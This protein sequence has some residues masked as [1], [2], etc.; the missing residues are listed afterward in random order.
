M[1]KKLFF[2]GLLAFI[3]NNLMAQTEAQLPKL[4]PVTPTAANLIKVGMGDV[5]KAT[6]A[7]TANM[8]LYEV[9]VG[10]F[11]LP[12]SL[13][14]F[15]QGNKTEEQSTRVGFGWSL[16]AGGVISRK[17]MDVAD[18]LGARAAAPADLAAETTQN[19]DYFTFGQNTGT[20]TSGA[21]T[22]PDEY[23]FS[24]GGNSGKFII[25][26]AGNPVVISHQN[27][28]IVTFANGGSAGIIT[29]TT[30]DGITYYFGG[31]AYDRIIKT[32]SPNLKTAFYLYKI[33]LPTG[34]Y[35]NLNYEKIQTESASGF[36]ETLALAGNCEQ[37]AGQYIVSHSYS[38]QFTQN[39]VCYL[40]N[41]TTSE[42]TKVDFI[43]EAMP[44]LSNDKRLTGL[45][46]TS[47]NLKEVKRY[48]FSYT[49]T[50]GFVNQYPNSPNTYTGGR[51]GRFYL[52]GI[53]EQSEAAGQV[54]N[55]PVEY[56]GNIATEYLQD[57]YG[58]DAY[59]FKNGK[60]NSS[61]LPSPDAYSTNLTGITW[62]D[63]S[64]DWHA[65]VNGMLK[66][67]A[68]PTKGTETFYYEPN[69]ISAYV[70]EPDMRAIQK[71]I[72]GGDQPTITYEYLT[73]LKDQTITLNYTHVV[74]S[75]HC[76]AVCGGCKFIQCIVRDETTNSQLASIYF[77]GEGSTY[78][79][80]FQ[81]VAGHQ[82][83]F[84][85]S[86]FPA[87]SCNRG[88]IMI[89]YDAAPPGPHLVNKEVSGVR[90][91]RIEKADQF[92][93]S[94]NKYFIYA[95]LAELNKSS[96]ISDPHVG[97]FSVRRSWVCGQGGACDACESYNYSSNGI[98][99]VQRMENSHIYY[100]NIIETTDPQMTNG[101]TEY[102]F[103]NPIVSAA[104]VV[105]RGSDMPHPADIT[106]P[107]YEGLV[108]KELV[109]DKN[110]QTKSVTE[111][112]YEIVTPI[113]VPVRTIY[114]TRLYTPYY[115]VVY[116][117][118]PAVILRN[119]LNSFNVSEN[120]Y[121]PGWVRIHDT[122]NT[123]Y[124]NAG[125]PVESATNYIY[126]TVDNV[127]PSGVT[128]TDSKGN[129]I[130]SEKKYPTDFPADPVLAA[131]VTANMISP[132]VEESKMQNLTELAKTKVI[133]QSNGAPGG[134][135]QPAKIQ[136]KQTETAAMEDRIL[137][138]G[139]DNKGNLTEVSKASDSKI[140]YLWDY[141]Q[142]LVTAEVKNSVKEDIAY[143]SFEADSKGNFT[144]AGNT[145]TDATA[146]T[147]KKVYDLSGG[148]ITAPA[149]AGTGK[150][151]IVS[152]WSKAGAKTVTGSSNLTTG[153][154]V[155]GW[156]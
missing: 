33:V 49:N 133:Y 32:E 55:Y 2:S 38:S 61:L 46:V 106:Y 69:T 70:D 39:E 43:Y 130:T 85:F 27:V 100:P 143:T 110:L 109:F 115:D 105:K 138:S 51:N 84:K 24:F 63:K 137:F 3:A 124:D 91:Q 29:I 13:S 66:K 97:L 9:R 71:Q 42:N 57:I 92:G 59:G 95:S 82:Y 116:P 150:P 41:I 6:G 86:L 131:M 111:T 37:A 146:P 151:Y 22:Q 113:H 107:G 5:N 114:I 134:G 148:A 132:A 101:G 88:D 60:S 26:D 127:L 48:G 56:Y 12:V 140:A 83:S 81:I 47:Q 52:T 99:N 4:L 136:Q 17:V 129:A 153:R 21:D 50:N 7:A 23:N 90:V 30:P 14:Y 96:G 80:T 40:S 121:M 74:L 45:A 44:D 145:T 123:M 93:A 118:D 19:L 28:K 76:S 20:S 152:Y 54:L 149:A 147:G 98:F 31:Q 112:N 119:N 73:V 16:I 102:T 122:K 135:F 125:H 62:A 11:K 67:I 141:N 77:L 144:Y 18:E 1:I 154:S 15:S 142:S 34:Q 155:S 53:S 25:D 139:Y 117:Q 128:T 36:A 65:S 8:P 79:G 64:P 75:E 10:S 120:Q 68:Y 58:Q 87:A 156:T 103:Y 78:N 89:S 108:K 126:G 104:A 35:I 72:Y 94:L